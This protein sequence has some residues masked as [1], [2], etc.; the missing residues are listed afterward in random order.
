[1]NILFYFLFSLLLSLFVNV[2]NSISEHFLY[3]L[4]FFGKCKQYNISEGLLIQELVDIFLFIYL[5]K[6]EYTSR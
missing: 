5:I 1:M 3:F 6:F 4:Y 2:N